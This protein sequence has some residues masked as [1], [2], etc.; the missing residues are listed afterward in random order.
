MEKRNEERERG[1]DEEKVRET[2][3]SS[4]TER[5]PDASASAREENPKRTARF[6]ATGRRC[7][8][9][10]TERAPDARRRRRH[11]TP[12]NPSPPPRRVS[13]RLVVARARDPDRARR[14][15]SVK[16]RDA[17]RC[18][19]PGSDARRETR[20]VPATARRAGR[21]T[22]GG[23]GTHHVGERELRSSL[24][25]SKRA[26]V[27]RRDDSYA[28]ANAKVFVICLGGTRFRTVRSSNAAHLAAIRFR[29]F[30]FRGF[31]TAFAVTKKTKSR[32]VDLPIRVGGY[33]HSRARVFFAR[34]TRRA[35]TE[36]EQQRRARV[37]QNVFHSTL[38]LDASTPRRRT[39]RR[40]VNDDE[41]FTHAN[42][43]SHRLDLRP[44]SASC[45][46]NSAP[47]TSSVAP[48]TTETA[49]DP[50]RLAYPSSARRPAAFPSA[51]H[52]RYSA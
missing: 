20:G 35:R 10:A 25:V 15:G 42:V 47:V 36:K 23:T 2:S 26:S 50:D 52:S 3:S 46:T 7:G 31:D 4:E 16:R 22:E 43:S 28:S 14:E 27:A 29:R 9:A 33:T 18:A 24:R 45:P 39:T 5:V 41:P 32:W 40:D 51:T 38:R 48:Y 37:F 44:S 1:R 21:G 19:E 34:R 17:S 49:P 13:R 12:K 8:R 30:T 6:R 11:G